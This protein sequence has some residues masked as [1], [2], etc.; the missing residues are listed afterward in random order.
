MKTV[1]GMKIKKHLVER[2]RKQEQTLLNC[3]IVKILVGNHSS[4][5]LII[6]LFHVDHFNK[7]KTK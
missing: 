7:L 6:L 4:N 1:K 5:H 2:R 3:S